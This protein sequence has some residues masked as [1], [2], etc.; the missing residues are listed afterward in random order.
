M[1]DEELVECNI[2][3]T[4]IRDSSLAAHAYWHQVAMSPMAHGMY[5]LGKIGEIDANR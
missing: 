5:V 1:S 2:C 4:M 3:Y